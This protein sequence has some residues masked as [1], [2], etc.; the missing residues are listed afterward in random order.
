ITAKLPGMM[1]PRLLEILASESQPAV[2]FFG[3][4]ATTFLIV[5]QF[6]PQF[7]IIFYRWSLWRDSR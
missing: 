4:I 5:A 1:P 7:F 3:G 2:V 6:L